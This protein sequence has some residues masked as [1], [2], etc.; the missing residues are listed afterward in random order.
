MFMLTRSN[1]IKTRHTLFVHV[2]DASALLDDLNSAAGGFVAT[3]LALKLGCGLRVTL[4]ILSNEGERLLEVPVVIAGRRFTHTANT[5]VGVFLKLED[6]LTPAAA[7]AYV[8]QP[9]P[10]REVQVA[11]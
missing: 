7:G 2:G 9:Q 4:A 8:H 6:A 10:G 5:K 1:P 3:L 11:C